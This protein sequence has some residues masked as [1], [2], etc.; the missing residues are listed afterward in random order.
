MIKQIKSWV[1]WLTFI[2]FRET[3][4]DTDGTPKRC[5]KCGCK[6]FDVHV[7]DAIEWTVCEEKY[8]CKDCGAVVAFWAYGYFNPYGAYYEDKNEK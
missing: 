5:T 7:L 2:M 1:L 6:D 8:I 3:V 4:Y